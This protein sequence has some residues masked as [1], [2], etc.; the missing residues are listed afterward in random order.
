MTGLAVTGDPGREHFLAQA[1][2]EG[3]RQRDN[4]RRQ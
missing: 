1:I 3:F 4:A 2:A